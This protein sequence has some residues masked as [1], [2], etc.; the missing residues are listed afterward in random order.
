VGAAIGPGVGAARAAVVALGLERRKA[1]LVVVGGG[2]AALVA[3]FAIDAVT[4]GAHL[5]RSVLG[6]GEAGDVVDVFDRRLRLMVHTFT[7]P[8]YPELLVACGALLLAGAIRR[9]RVSAWFGPRWAARAGFL[10]A[11]AGVLLGTVANDSGSVLLVIGTIYLAISAGYYW[12]TQAE[13]RAA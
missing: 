5:S 1:V 6:A 13:S 8:V 7:H 4:G 10:G 11:V 2:A 9:E 12:A 3:L